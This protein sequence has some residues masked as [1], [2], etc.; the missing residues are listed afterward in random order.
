MS[1]LKVRRATLADIPSLYACQLAAYGG[2]KPEDLCDE[3]VLAMQVQNFPD[4]IIVAVKGELVVGYATSLIV[5]LDDE[6]PWYSYNEITGSGTFTTHTP[7]GDTL[8]GADIAVH[9]EHQGKGISGR[10]YKAR[11]RILKRFNLRRMVAGGR[12]PGY[13]KVVSKYS[14]EQYVQEVIDGNLTDPALNAHLKAGYTVRGVHM[15]YLDDEQSLDYATFLEY[16]NPDFNSQR[17]RIAAAPLKAPVRKVRV[18]AVQYQMRSITTFEEFA[19]QVQVF[20]TTAERYHCH[21]LLFPELFTV[22]LFNTFAQRTSSKEAILKVAHLIDRFRE[23]FIAEAA[24]AGIFIIAGSI[25]VEIDGELFNSSHLF[26]PTGEVHTQEKLHLTTEERRDFGFSAGSRLR[27]FDTGHARIGILLGYDVL[28]PELARLQTLAGAEILFVPFSTDERKAYSRISCT[29]R[30]RAVENIV[31][32]AMAGNVGNLP[33][34]ESFLVN[35]GESVIYTPCDFAFPEDGIAASADS[36]SETVVISDLDLGALHMTREM[37]SVRPLRD[38]RSD[39]YVL[40]SAIPIEKVR[41]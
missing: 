5:E 21:F 10:L 24:R 22:Q 34:V 7:C 18:C 27:V 15:G 37:G 40:N 3:R 1:R 11:K 17:R 41:V 23:L 19:N 39:F 28:F 26:T 4:G 16:E 9:P 33:Q 35:Y 8:Y 13:K 20:V 38:R 25:P 32:V 31:Y 2:M 14:P 36:D 29:A 6:S 30:A 12:I